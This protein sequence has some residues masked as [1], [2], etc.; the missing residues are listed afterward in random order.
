[1][2]GGDAD[3]RQITLTACFTASGRGRYNLSGRI[4]AGCEAVD[5]PVAGAGGVSAADSQSKWRR[6][7]HCQR[8]TISQ[9]V[10]SDG[11]RRRAVQVRTVAPVD[12]S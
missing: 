1:M 10:R 8:S 5:G 6:N 4:S 9:P 12:G 7:G 3:L 11:R 2:R